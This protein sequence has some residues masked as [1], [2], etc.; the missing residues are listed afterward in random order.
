MKHSLIKHPLIL[1]ITL[2]MMMLLMF[3][4]KPYMSLM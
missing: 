3:D 1:F 4:S 2:Y